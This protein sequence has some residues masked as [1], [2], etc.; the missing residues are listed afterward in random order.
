MSEAAGGDPQDVAVVAPQEE[1]RFSQVL[2]LLATGNFS[3]LLAACEELE[4]SSL[5]SEQLVPGDGGDAPVT[6]APEQVEQAGLLYAAHMLAYLLEGQLDSAR[7]LWK[8]TPAAVQ[9][10][11]QAAAAHAVLAARWRRQY[12]EFFAQLSAGPWDPRLQQLALEVT[13]RSRAEL[14]DKIGI[15]YKVI[16]IANVGAMLGLD[17]EAARS[18]CMSRG[19]AIDVA[20]NVSPTPVK[21]GEDLMQMGEAQLQKLAEYMAHLEQAPCRA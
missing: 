3:D 11:A 10:Q 1:S 13:S 7:F 16:S 8:R 15:A 12:T 6:A 18:V 5:S 2:R 19:W 21:S 20:G 17:A 4:L 9:E 14:L